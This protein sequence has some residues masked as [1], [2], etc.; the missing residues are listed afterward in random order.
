MSIATKRA[1]TG[2]AEL[3]ANRVKS[4]SCLVTNVVRS[5]G[6]SRNTTSPGKAALTRSETQGLLEILEKN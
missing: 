1:K 5:T 2:A 4:Q 6:F 3:A